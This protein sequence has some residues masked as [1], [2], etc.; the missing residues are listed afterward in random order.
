MENLFL[1]ADLLELKADPDC[2]AEG[3]V[4]EAKLDKTK[5]PLATLLVQKGTLK[6]GDVVV[7]GNTWGKI[8]AMF[9][10]KESKFRKLSHQRQW[11]SSA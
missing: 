9:D 1:V 11:K 8:K 5:G 3:V 6:V 7:A 2:S 4:V 10:D